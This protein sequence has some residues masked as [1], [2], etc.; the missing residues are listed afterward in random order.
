VS[1]ERISLDKQRSHH[2]TEKVEMDAGFLCPDRTYTARQYIFPTVSVSTKQKR[3]EMADGLLSRK[4]PIRKEVKK[5]ES[6]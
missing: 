4:N 3:L 1:D 6:F 5:D 2:H